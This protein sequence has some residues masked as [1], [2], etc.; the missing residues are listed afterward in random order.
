VHEARG[1][2]GLS[3][4]VQ[5]GLPGF[6]G[7]DVGMQMLVPMEIEEGALAGSQ[8]RRTAVNWLRVGHLHADQIPV[9]WVI[10]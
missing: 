9:A 4:V 8:G 1:I 6:L 5:A 7:P 10:A 3:V 2:L